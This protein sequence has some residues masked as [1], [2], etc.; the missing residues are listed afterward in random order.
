MPFMCL[1][2]MPLVMMKFMTLMASW[3][4]NVN[5]LVF[6][7]ASCL[8]P[9]GIYN[10]HGKCVC[11]C[12]C[13]IVRVIVRVIVCVIVCACACGRMCDCVCACVFVCTCAC[14]H[15]VCPYVSRTL[16]LS[17]P[18]LKAILPCFNFL[19]MPPHISVV[20]LKQQSFIHLYH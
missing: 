9:R 8:S 5:R 4:S 15:V 11:A 17:V 1:L 20:G 16:L 7:H 13:V 6:M 18:P 3:Y 10:V 19:E 14:L 2:T 12:V